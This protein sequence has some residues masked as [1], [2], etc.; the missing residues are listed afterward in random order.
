LKLRRLL[1]TLVGA[2]TAAGALLAAAPAASALS[3]LCPPL[4]KNCGQQT[5]G[6]L[7]F[8]HWWDFVPLLG[9]PSGNGKVSV[10]FDVCKDVPTPQMPRRGFAGSIDQGPTAVNPAATD[11]YGKYQYLP[12]FVTYDL[13]CSGSLIPSAATLDTN[14]G[15]IGMGLATA[16]V[17]TEVAVHRVT[18]SPDF[19]TVLDPMLTQVSATM[20]D[21]VFTPWVGISIILLGLLL[22]WGARRKDLPDA[23]SR[24]ALA[25]AV[26]VV[27]TVAFQYP[28]IAGHVAA[29]VLTTVTNTIDFTMNG[30]TAADP[31]EAR[32]ALLTN[33]VLVGPWL[34]GEFGSATSAT[35]TSFGPPLLDSR[36]YTY[37]QAAKAQA[38]PAAGKAMT[39]AKR[40]AFS[41]VTQAVQDRDPDA[42]CYLTG[43]CGGRAG[44]GGKALLAA[45]CTVPFM[46]IADLI[47]IAA[48][49]VIMM[50]VMFAPALAP[51]VLHSRRAA[52]TGLSIAGASVWNGALMALAGAAMAYVAHFVL[53]S[54]MAWPLQL[55]IV[56][57]FTVIMWRATGP[58][59]RWQTVTTMSQMGS[60]AGQGG[61]PG[62]KWWGKLPLAGVAGAVAG[63]AAGEKHRDRDAREQPARQSTFED[64]PA[65]ADPN[66]RDITGERT[67]TAD[68]PL[69]LPA[70]FETSRTALPDIYRPGET[71]PS[72]IDSRPATRAGRDEVFRLWDARSS[73]WRYESRDDDVEA[74]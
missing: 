49:L 65:V 28:L 52:L 66:I 45:L 9:D 14:V 67:V 13:G 59:R 71:L 5:P 18:S 17:A 26:L 34:E 57:M 10:G 64:L 4:N 1:A 15:N 8:K 61:V 37:G 22:I 51:F 12:Q 30:E 20:R 6:P 41:Q 68:A 55:L 47:K 63:W 32:A 29:R 58:V 54:Q 3:I 2:A 19:L 43:K 46:L 21:A 27:A 35:A 16:A 72:T 48:V 25:M 62:G 38:D 74:T 39:K 40:E 11:V 23:V 24:S 60:A 36:K 50:L 73:S 70:G 44:A 69:E 7:Q 42:Y 56:G 31:S 33:T 53:T